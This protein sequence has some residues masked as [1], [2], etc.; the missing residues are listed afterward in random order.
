MIYIVIPVHNRYNY[1]NSCLRTAFKKN[2]YKN[3]KVVVVDDGSTD[4]TKKNIKK[5]FPKTKVLNGNGSLF[6]SGAVSKGIKYVLS[7]CKNKDWILLMNNDVEL[8]N[9]TII[10]LLNTAKKYK[11]KCIVSAL[12]VSHSDKKTILKT[13]SIVKSWFLNLTNHVFMGEKLID[14]VKKEPI[15]VDFVTGRCL[16]HPVELFKIIG[17]YNCKLFPHYGADDEFSIRLKRNLYKIFVQPNSI[18]FLKDQKRNI[19]NLSIKNIFKF[20]FGIKSSSNIINKLKIS[21]LCVPFYAKL[22]FFLVGILKSIFFF[23]KYKLKK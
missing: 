5:K 14:V 21:L 1:T 4:G 12:S 23:F 16:L 20:F 7:I 3:I 10:K 8:S 22:T 19:K 18:I 17:N 2:S 9:D 11:R 13:G 6:W 15:E